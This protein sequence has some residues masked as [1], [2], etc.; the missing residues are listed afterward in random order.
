[1]GWKAIKEEFDIK[2]NIKV[3]EGF[4]Y[5]GSGYIGDLISINMKTAE[6]KGNPAF[7]EF[8]QEKYPHL[9]KVSQ[10]ELI[11]LINKK[12]N[13]QSS[14]PVFTYKNGEIIQKFCEQV[15]WPNCTH[16]GEMMYENTF[17]TDKEEVIGWAKKEAELRIEIT[18]QNISR[19]EKKLNEMKED[20]GNAELELLK[21]KENYIN[22]Q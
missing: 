14:I 11:D 16:D 21:I 12:D 6:I 19:I 17:S 15:G 2:H 18:K 9:L 20:L 10:K 4:I 7:P 3:F 5:I 8:I 1:M 22:K 13:F